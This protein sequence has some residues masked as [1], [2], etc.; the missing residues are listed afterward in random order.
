M[1]GNMF[2]CPK[3]LLRHNTAQ[4]RPRVNSIYAINPATSSTFDLHQ[5][6]KNCLQTFANTVHMQTDKHVQT[7]MRTD[8]DMQSPPDTRTL[9]YP[10]LPSLGISS[11]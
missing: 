2:K 5:S 6:P 9:K 8:K 3:T 7:H 1:D 10:S 11:P 4:H